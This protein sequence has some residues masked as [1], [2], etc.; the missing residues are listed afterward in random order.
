M[1]CAPVDKHDGELAAVATAIRANAEVGFFRAA[2]CDGEPLSSPGM[3][4]IGK[5]Y[6]TKS[7]VRAVRTGANQILLI[8]DGSSHEVGFSPVEC[9][10]GEEGWH[11][12][13]VS[14]NPGPGGR[15]QLTKKLLSVRA[16]AAGLRGHAASGSVVAEDSNK[17]RVD[18]LF[19]MV[20]QS[21]RSGTLNM[22]AVLLSPAE[23][24]VTRELLLQNIGRA[25]RNS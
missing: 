18:M 23:G 15:R 22:S 8:G 4:A 7:G 17:S 14:P 2:N 12:D 25:S 13:R 21:P 10:H 19:G 11:L 24:V 6:Y 1:A 16:H 9:T 3:L 20:S 5:R